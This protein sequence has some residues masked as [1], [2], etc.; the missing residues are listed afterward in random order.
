MSTLNQSARFNLV[1]T[2]PRRSTDMTERLNTVTVITSRGS[3]SLSCESRQALLG[4]I[5][6]L[7]AAA[8]IA[9]AFTDVGASRPVE[10]SAAD[11]VLLFDLLEAWSRR[12]GADEMPAGLWELRNALAGA[13]DGGKR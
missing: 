13:E 1:S 10:V 11:R 3:V 2:W 12:V 8:G 5:D 9:S 7:V 6:G 4:E